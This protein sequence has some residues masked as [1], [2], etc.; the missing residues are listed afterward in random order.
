[1]S[2]QVG[3]R[4]RASA[5]LAPHVSRAAAVGLAVLLTF[6]YG[7]A[8]HAGEGSDVSGAGTA[9]AVGDARTDE[10]AAPRSDDAQGRPGKADGTI[11]ISA[12]SSDTDLVTLVVVTADGRR[13]TTVTPVSDASDS[14]VAGP[15][16]LRRADATVAVAAAGKEGGLGGIVQ[17]TGDEILGAAEGSARIRPAALVLP[18][19]GAAESLGIQTGAGLLMV[20]AGVMTL[21][22]RRRSTG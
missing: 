12:T 17:R 7:A 13:T 20:L 5:A 18:Q 9:D 22:G 8:A 3:A 1:M 10:R 19:T 15:G 4:T 21:R 16:Q 6:G 14:L 11:E 2:K